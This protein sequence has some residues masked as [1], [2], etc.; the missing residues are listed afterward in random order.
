MLVKWHTS[1]QA[2]ESCKVCIHP[3]V[4]SA[5]IQKFWCL[6]ELIFIRIPIGT[7][8]SCF[9]THLVPWVFKW[10]F[11]DLHHNNHSQN[12]LGS[13]SGHLYHLLHCPSASVYL[14]MSSALPHQYYMGSWKGSRWAE[15]QLASGF[16]EHKKVALG[17]EVASAG[18]GFQNT[19]RL[20]CQW[21]KQEGQGRLLEG[22][23]IHQHS[24]WYLICSELV[25]RVEGALGRPWCIRRA[26]GSER[27]WELRLQLH[28]NTPPSV[29]WDLCS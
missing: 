17:Q 24:L 9:L 12:R 29:A 11:F 27:G 14:C 3:G 23:T 6:S 19:V 2:L 22:Q 1:V 28:I 15:N 25:A 16:W 5:G 18:V 20:V 26:G 13:P 10:E 8:E 21:D 7:S 4:L